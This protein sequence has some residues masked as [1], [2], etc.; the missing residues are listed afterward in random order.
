LKKGGAR[1]SFKKALNEANDLAELFKAILTGA[2][3]MLMH[4]SKV[5]SF[6]ANQ[7]SNA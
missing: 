3:L 7:K 1:R 5:F 6:N 2:K 4:Q